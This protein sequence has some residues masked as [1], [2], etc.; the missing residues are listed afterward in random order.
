MQALWIAVAV[1][2]HVQVLLTHETSTDPTIVVSQLKHE[3]LSQ[4]KDLFRPTVPSP[5]TVPAAV[6]VRVSFDGENFW[7]VCALGDACVLQLV[8]AACGLHGLS[9][10]HVR[11][12]DS[13]RGLT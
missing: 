9:V 12:L 4:S 2:R 3:I 6:D 8:Q 13:T 1:V 5:V 7:V 11:A 10:D